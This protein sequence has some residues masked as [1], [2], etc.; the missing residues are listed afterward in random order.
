VGIDALREH[1]L[2]PI[3]HLIV[4]KDEVLAAH[5]DLAPALFQAF[6]E[7]KVPYVTR[8]HHGADGAST[9]ADTRYRTVMSVLGGDPLPYGIAPNRPIIDLL[10]DHAISQGILDRPRDVADLF[11]AGT[12]DLVG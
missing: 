3:N 4:V 6:V 11:A 10:I 2:Y 1:G 8:L 7:A 5:P 12:L 9:E